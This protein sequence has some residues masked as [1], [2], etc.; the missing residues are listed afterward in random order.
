MMFMPWAHQKMPMW[1]ISFL[2]DVYCMH[3]PPL[4]LYVHLILSARESGFSTIWATVCSSWVWINS[5]TSGRS[6]LNPEG[7]LC[8]DYVR[9]AN[10]M[11][12]RN[13][14]LTMSKSIQN[15]STIMFFRIYK[16]W[17]VSMDQ[18]NHAINLICVT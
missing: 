15:L 4:R 2:K 14:V 17:E 3:Q 13:L 10:Q 9:L 5:F 1:F 12:S 6:L 16:I 18:T 7:N 8:R 11:L